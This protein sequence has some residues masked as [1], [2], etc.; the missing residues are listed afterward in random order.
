[1]KPLANLYRRLRATTATLSGQMVLTVLLGLI[2][3][4]AVGWSV[5]ELQRRHR[6]TELRIE[7]VVER[8]IGVVDLLERSPPRQYD[9]IVRTAQNR[10]IR[11][12]LADEPLLNQGHDNDRAR[13]VAAQLRRQLS[14]AAND[15]RLSLHAHDLNDPFNARW[16]RWLRGHLEAFP[17]AEERL[18]WWRRLR[19]EERRPR[20]P[21]DMLLSVPLAEGRWLNVGAWVMPLSP[22]FQRDYS[23]ILI[24]AA[25]ALV[26]A[27]LLLWLLRRVTEPLAALTREADR[28]GRGEQVA[29]L[30]ERGPE[31]IRQL[32]RSFNRMGGRIERFIQ[33]RSRMLAA[34]SHDL[35]TPITAL[36]V[37]A[38]LIDDELTRDK[39]LATLDEMQAIAE[40]TLT[41]MREEAIQEPTRQV[42]I[43]ALLDSL[44]ADLA[45]TGGEVALTEQ[46]VDLALSCRPVAL[47]R[48]FANLLDNALKYG[49]RADVALYDTALGAVIQI[50]DVGPGIPEADRERVFEP[51]TRL[52]RSRSRDT[53]GVGLGLAIARSIVRQHGGDIVLSSRQE[54]GL[55]VTVTLPKGI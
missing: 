34:V 13:W 20:G 22:L 43:A 19:H 37:R 44:C 49:Q 53:G 29:P 23:L 28:L 54:G 50:D 41:F 39:I 35:R 25:T 14:L 51:F 52:E 21:L 32:V 7:S 42:N 30:V 26:L 4:Q 2:I 48:A 38:E 11:L 55:R 10:F 15:I 9:R 40:A 12:Y 16:R 46:P 36:R 18:Q 1:M 8:V 45:D 33:D 47:K 27:V 31:D 5:V 6:L 24:L 17:A 3:T